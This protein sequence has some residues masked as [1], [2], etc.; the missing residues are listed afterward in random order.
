MRAKEKRN[1][2]Y[3]R[4]INLTQAPLNLGSQTIMSDVNSDLNIKRFNKRWAYIPFELTGKFDFSKQ[5]RVKTVKNGQHGYEL[6]CPFEYF[7][8]ENP[9]EKGI[10]YVSRG[11]VEQTFIERFG[12]LSTHNANGYTTIRGVV[13]QVHRNKDDENNDYFDNGLNQVNLQEFSKLHGVSSNANTNLLFREVNFDNSNSNV[14]PLTDSID[15]L[16]KFTISDSTHTTWKNLYAGVGFFT[17]FSNM[18]FWVCL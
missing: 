11:F 10:I 18:F 1:E 3:K 17:V 15:S 13:T 8:D 12:D 16:L 9:N 4:N 6:I 7:K 14:F 5:L 2:L